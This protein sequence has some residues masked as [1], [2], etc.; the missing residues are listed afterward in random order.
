[1]DAKPRSASQ[2]ARN[3]RLGMSISSGRLRYKMV[4]S[5]A[6]AA[7]CLVA[8]IRLAAAVPFSGAAAVA[9]AL[10]VVLVAAAAWRGLIYLRIARGHAP[11]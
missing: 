2:P 11:R 10:G 7:L 8:L 1:M 6:F 5:F 3:A 4:T 9:F